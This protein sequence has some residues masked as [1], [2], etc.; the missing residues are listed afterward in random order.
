VGAR[1]PDPGLRGEK[2]RLT[3]QF[4]QC[5][6]RLLACRNSGYA[7][8]RQLESNKRRLQ[9]Q[10][11]ERYQQ[12]ATRLCL[13]PESSRQS[14]SFETAEK[15]TILLKDLQRAISQADA[16]V[17]VKKMK[18]SM[19]PRL[20]PLHRRELLNDTM[21]NDQFGMSLLVP[22]H[23]VVQ[24]ASPSISEDETG[25]VKVDVERPRRHPELFQL[26]RSPGNGAAAEDTPPL[27]QLNVTNSNSSHRVATVTG[28]DVSDEGGEERMNL[29]PA[30]ELAPIT[31]EIAADEGGDGSSEDPPRVPCV[32]SLME[33]QDT[34]SVVEVTADNDDVI[35]TNSSL[36]SDEKSDIVEQPLE[37]AF[38][39][40]LMSNNILPEKEEIV[41]TMPD[42][43]N[44]EVEVESEPLTPPPSHPAP[45][46]T[47]HNSM[48][49]ET[50][51]ENH[52]DMNHHQSMD[53]ELVEMI[54]RDSELTAWIAKARLR[55]RTPISYKLTRK[56]RHSPS[57][58]S[59]VHD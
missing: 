32:M 39:D 52:R 16:L 6:E 18:L 50:S 37:P 30:V 40:R 55:P 22:P 11:A 2:E 23:Q 5:G 8:A 58:S 35:E 56:K 25:K 13:E 49:E 29:D 17:K 43:F 38:D 53:E 36:V 46:D 45:V 27:Q 1:P 20:P 33:G 21:S 59:Y 7:L 24:Q 14:A 9:L 57:R 26:L 42:G 51:P 41:S 44:E 54:M 3:E 47:N 4:Y 28:T 10:V 12:M 31:R 48:S 15:D 34:A 19:T